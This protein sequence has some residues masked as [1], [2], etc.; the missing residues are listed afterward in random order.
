MTKE[1]QEIVDAISAKYSDWILTKYQYFGQFSHEDLRTEKNIQLSPVDKATYAKYGLEWYPTLTGFMINNGYFLDH[2]FDRYFSVTE[3][4]NLAKELGG[5]LAYR[6]YRAK[7]INVIRNQW[8]I[9]ALLILATYAAALSPVI[10]ELVKNKQV[11][12]LSPQPAPSV[13]VK[14]DTAVLN[15]YIEGLKSKANKPVQSLRPANR[16]QNQKAARTQ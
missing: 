9:N 7:E 16:S 6:K 4:G 15:A 5:H 10:V 14:I 1:E 2:E 3:K 13:I 8:L 11:T 12:E